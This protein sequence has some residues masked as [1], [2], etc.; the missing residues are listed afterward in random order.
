MGLVP[1]PEHI[2][3]QD[4]VDMAAQIARRYLDLDAL[5]RVAQDA[6]PLRS[7]VR[8]QGKE[9]SGGR[10]AALAIRIT[11]P[12]PTIG[13]IKDSAFQ[14]YYPENIE[15]LELAGAQTIFVSPLQNESLPDLDALYI[16][17]GFPETHAKALA[18]NRLFRD[19]I[20]SLAEGGLPIYAE[21]GGLMYLGKELVLENRTYPMT[22]VLPIVY[23]FSKKPQGHGYSIVLVEGENPYFN[24]GTEIRG[25]EFHY[26]KVL[27]WGG[28]NKDLVFR[29]Q[30]GKGI[31]NSR[32]G[33][34]YK[35]VLATYSHI[36]ALGTPDWAAA[37]VHNAG[38]YQNLKKRQSSSK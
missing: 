35:N 22:G 6:E 1:T 11:E 18:A 19:K 33:I 3:V 21:C 13:I 36:H 34:C 29:M 37:M 10:T 9:T 38:V 31:H 2:W 23:G 17:G 20:K 25:H 32:D 15:A 5:R 30:R 14:F 16:G 27:K 28:E 12:G 4:S 7:E 26:S 8:T 24:V